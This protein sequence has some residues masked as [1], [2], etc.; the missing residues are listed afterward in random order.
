[1]TITNTVLQAGTVLPTAAAAIVTGGAGAV[2]VITRMV[3]ANS[4]ASAATVTVYRVP[5]AGTPGAG[6]VIVS[7]RSIVAAP[8]TD[9]M[10]EIVGMVLGPGDTI[11]AL[12]GTA[13]AINAFAS[14]Y[15]VT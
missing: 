6:N 8:G 3:M 9:L 14:G 1:M 11:Q 4:T 13:S 10:P 5:S 2:T 15:V 7:G 12:A